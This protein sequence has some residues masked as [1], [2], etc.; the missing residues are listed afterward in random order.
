MC[1]KLEPISADTRLT[2]TRTGRLDPDEQLFVGK[3]FDIDK[4]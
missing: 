1:L 2:T 4:N 3:R